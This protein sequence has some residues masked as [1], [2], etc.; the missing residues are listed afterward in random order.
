[1]QGPRPGHPGQGQQNPGERGAYRS[2][3]QT[4][5]LATQALQL[6]GYVPLSGSEPREGIVR[7]L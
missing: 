5:L 4:V 7:L 1:M 2:P 3:R 6:I